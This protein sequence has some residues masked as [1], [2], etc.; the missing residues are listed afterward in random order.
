[1]IP[2]TQDFLEESNLG[3]GK[4]KVRIA[5]RPWPDETLAGDLQ[6]LKQ[7][8]DC[9]L[10]TIGPAADGVDR[11]LD[12]RIVLAYRSE[13][14]VQIAALVL[15]PIFLKQ[16][17]VLQALQPRRSPAVAD[18]RRIGRKA[19]QAEKEKGPLKCSGGEKRPAHIVRV[20]GVPIVG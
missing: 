1:M 15:Q 3:A 2:P 16:R 12:R 5:V 4:R 20:L 19:H 8:G 17:Y 9:I 11:A 7:T 13:L 18:Q 10:I 6:S 14:P